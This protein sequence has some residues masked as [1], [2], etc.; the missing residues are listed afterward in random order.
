MLMYNMSHERAL[1]SQ[2]GFIVS[3]MSKILAWGFE[4][5]DKKSESEAEEAI[6]ETLRAGEV[7]TP[8]P[9]NLET[10][11]EEAAGG[12]GIFYANERT[13]VPITVFYLHGGAYYSD[14]SPFH[15][16]FI[17]RLIDRT[18]AMVVAPAYRLVPFAT[19]ADAFDLIV[20]VYRDH[21]EAHPER[22]VVLMGDSAGGGLALA[23]TEHLKAEGIR[24]PDELVLLS[25]WVDVTMENPEIEDYA[26]EDPW[27]SVEALKVCGRH[28]AGDVGPA[29]WHVSPI[30]GDLAGIGN[31]LL[32]TGTKEVLYP[33]SM[34]LY[35]LLDQGVGTEL[36]VAEDMMHVYPLMPIPEALP[37]QKAI[38]ERVAR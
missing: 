6:E 31:V 8:A 10:R 21:V 12:G 17:E 26:D 15:W 34:R 2:G 23:L 18:D 38:F 11:F 4:L 13:D 36:I 25:P 32:I 1:R 27:L 16:R 22:K 29:D 30:N 37:A 5:K 24:M 35:E 19:W 9:K 28:W 33:D 7:P 14:F 20:P 3:I